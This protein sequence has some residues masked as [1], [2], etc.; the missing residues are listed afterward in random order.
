LALPTFGSCIFRCFAGRGNNPKR[1]TA[2]SRHVSVAE[3]CDREVRCNTGAAPA[4]VSGESSAT[5]TGSGDSPG[6]EGAAGDDPEPGDLRI[7]APPTGGPE[8]GT[9]PRAEEEA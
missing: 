3:R 2:N 8:S 1:V 6:R 7:V 4:T 5:A 9:I